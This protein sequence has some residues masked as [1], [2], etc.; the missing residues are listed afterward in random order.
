MKAMAHDTDNRFESTT[1]MLADMDEFRKDPAMLF[2]YN[3]P[4]LDEVT[5]LTP[6]P[7]V[8][9]APKTTAEKVAQRADPQLRKAKTG[10][11][12]AEAEAQRRRRSAQRRRQE[13]QAKRDNVATIA[14]IACSLVAVIAI[15]IFLL[16]LFGGGLTAPQSQTVQVPYLEGEFYDPD[17]EMPEGLTLKAQDPVFNDEYEAG[18]I[19][20]QEPHGGVFVAPGN[21][22][23]VK[24]SKGPQ[25]EPI[26]MP[27]LQGLEQSVAQ[28]QLKN[29]DLDLQVEIPTDV[30][31]DTVP[32]GVVMR[33]VPS[34]GTELSSGQTVTL[35]VSQGP[36]VIKAKVPNVV[37]MDLDRAIRVL[38]AA[39]F[40]T[41]DY[42]L[43]TSAHSKGE[44]IYQSVEKN[45]VVDVNTV[46]TLKVSKGPEETTEPTTEPTQ[47]TEEQTVIK[48]LLIELP[49]GM[50]E[51]YV[52][53]ITNGGAVV[54][55]FT[56]QPDSLYL[57]VEVKGTGIQ[58]YKIN[59]PGI[60]P[61]I[62]E[63][64]FTA[65]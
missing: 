36:K 23:Y 28:N 15:G 42:E 12:T 48:T 11:A 22:V 14:I 13:A 16:V 9:E 35:Y 31:S 39:G 59:I 2:E 63:V 38:D 7:V 55:E 4:P 3:T 43:V 50:V 57:E 64:D 5:R 58:Y 25:P 62:K 37:G 29:L 26:K 30:Y 21:T 61:V 20:S 47:P 45:T 54:H 40:G 41:P 18:R 27:E 1:A 56:V 46:I 17:M 8:A 60:D 51:P 52:L 34:Y 32:A 44:V 10:A 24:V 6:P 49:D 19:I 53:T 65:E 33:T